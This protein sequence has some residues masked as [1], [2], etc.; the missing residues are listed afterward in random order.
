[1]RLTPTVFWALSLTEWRAMLAGHFPKAA[2]SMR[3]ADLDALLQL[4]PDHKNV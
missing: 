3:R 4:Y 1:M 2:P